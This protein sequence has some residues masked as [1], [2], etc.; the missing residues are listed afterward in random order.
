MTY[1]TL[2]YILWG[3]LCLPILV[4]GVKLFASLLDDLRT[5][6]GKG[7]KAREKAER[8]R[9]LAEEERR[10]EFEEEYERKHERTEDR[11]NRNKRGARK[12]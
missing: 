6:N 2:K 11:G 4:L 1:E 8:E 9:Q 5:V 10:R 12:R 3:L 7:K